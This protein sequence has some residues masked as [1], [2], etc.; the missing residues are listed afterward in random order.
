MHM[1]NLCDAHERT[2][3]C[4][5]QVYNWSPLNCEQVAE[6]EQSLSEDDAREG[7]SD[8]SGHSSEGY[9]EAVAPPV[10]TASSEN[11]ATLLSGIAALA[12]GQGMLMEKLSD[13]EKIVGTVQFDMMWV[14]DDM[15]SVHQ[16]MDRFADYVCDVQDAAVGVETLKE[17]VSMDTS[18]RLPWKGKDIAVDFPSAP[19]ATTSHAEQQFGERPHGDVQWTH[20]DACRKEGGSSAEEMQPYAK[21][22]DVYTNTLALTEAGRMD[23]GYAQDVSPDVGSPLGQQTRLSIENDLVEEESQQME[24]SCL[25]TQIPTPATTRSMWTDFTTAVRDWPAPTVV[26]TE[27]EK[28]WVSAKKG[29]W[30]MVDYAKDNARNAS[31]QLVEL[32]RTLN[33]NLMPDKQ[34]P[35]VPTGGG[36]G[37]PQHRYTRLPQPRALPVERGEAQLVAK[38]RRQCSHDTTTR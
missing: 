5:W 38:G 22:R 6:E 33:L 1:C 23:W 27:K 17:A 10:R 7:S 30:D 2:H 12:R 37:T 34:G 20:G 19:G 18:P 21:E 4:L 3:A 25:S 31:A 29:R 8:V 16:A 28:G 13:L 11:L 35:V 9:L 26:V 15:E 24:M 36:G 32:P 14:H